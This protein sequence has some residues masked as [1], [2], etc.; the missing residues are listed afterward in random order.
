[1]SKRV[2]LSLLGLVSSLS[3]PFAANSFADEWTGWSG[4][5]V[6]K[7]EMKKEE[8]GEA[9]LSNEDKQ[10]EHALKRLNVSDGYSPSDEDLWQDAYRMSAAPGDRKIFAQ[11]RAAEEQM[12][13]EQ[14]GK[15]GESSIESQWEEES[16]YQG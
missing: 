12:K 8:A 16:D 1:M 7:D 13:T 2:T 11:F 4:P 15:V 5:R 3:L 14:A 6:S 10:L 9:A